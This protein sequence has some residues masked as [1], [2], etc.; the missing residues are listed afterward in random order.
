MHYDFIVVGAGASG[1]MAA[2]E[3]AKNGAKTALIE[4]NSQIGKKL[5]ITGAGRCNLTNKAPLEEF[6]S[7]IPKNASFLRD[8]FKEF[9][10]EALMKFFQENGV[11]LK[12]EER[13]RIFPKS[14][15]ASTITSTLFSL[16]A[17]Y[18]VE[19]FLEKELKTL[20]IEDEKVQGI[21]LK[22][23]EKFFSKTVLLATG[24]KSYPKTGST[25]DGFLLAEKFGH[26]IEKLFPAEAPLCSEDI[27]IKDKI[28]QGLTLENAKI[29]LLSSKNKILSSQELPMIFTHFGL[30]GPAI[31]ACSS[32]VFKEEE[33]GRKLKI[34]IDVLPEKSLDELLENLKFLKKKEPKKLIKNLYKNFCQERYW[35]FLLQQ[36]KIEANKESE[37]LKDKELLALAELLKGFKIN[38]SQIFPLEKAFVTGGGISLKEIDPKTMQSK[39]IKGLFFAGELLDIH[40]HTGGFNLTLAFSTGFL[41]GKSA[42]ELAK[43]C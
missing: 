39:L 43:T 10:N 17:K 15:K 11:E 9:D 14:D 5:L 22:S 4:K 7:A 20:L 8:A 26:K 21:L 29:S 33:K 2:I 19:L 35:L 32:F 31:L 37:T 12:E 23:G 41:A 42:A 30:S 6:F 27:F 13:G 24:G 36:A 18:Q 38:I 28:L 16:L 34:K 3:A 25:G 1:L 40:A